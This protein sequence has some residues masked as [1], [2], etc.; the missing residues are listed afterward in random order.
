MTSPLAG[1]ANGSL[2]RAE[3]VGEE[4]LADDGFGDDDLPMQPDL[5]LAVE[6]IT[7]SA[8]SLTGALESLLFVA[9]GPAEVAT[10]AKALQLHGD[11]VRAGLAQ[12]A[13]LY[14]DAKSRP[15]LQV[16]NQKYELVSAPAG[17]AAH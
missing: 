4:Q 8:P 9:D 11:T 12:L 15:G 16:T 14:R 5:G 3:G 1:G 6:E 2:L 17:S 13:S 7:V 10:L